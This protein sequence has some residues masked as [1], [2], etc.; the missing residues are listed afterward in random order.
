M[1]RATELTIDVSPLGRARDALATLDG[2]GWT[3]TDELSAVRVSSRPGPLHSLD[4]LA[5]V[6]DAADDVVA[7]SRIAGQSFVLR[8]V[9]G[10]MEVVHVPSLAPREVFEDRDIWPVAERAWSEDVSAVMQ[11][12]LDWVID[13]TLALHRLLAVPAGLEVRVTTSAEALVTMVLGASAWEFDRFLPS[14]AALRLFIALD[15]AGPA[16]R[17]GVLTFAGLEPGIVTVLGAHQRTHPGAAAESADDLP[18]PTL[19]TPCDVRTASGMSW[20]PAFRHIKQVAAYLA[21]SALASSRTVRD[22]SLILTYL[23]FKRL[24]LTLTRD[25]EILPK[26]ADG[27]IVLFL[28]AT[29][30]RSPDKL[31]AIRQVASVY[32]TGAEFLRHPR[33]V[34]DSAEMVYLGLRSD[35]IAEAVRSVRVAETQILE[36]V[37]QTARATQDLLKSVTDRAIA[38][39][40][41]VGGVLIANASK[42][43]PTSTGRGLLLV[44]ATFLAFLGIWSLVVEG[45]LLSLPLRKLLEDFD[46]RPT[47]LSERQRFELR[48]LPTVMA[49][50]SKLRLVQ[51][52]VPLVYVAAAALVVVFGHPDRFV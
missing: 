31:L 52:A 27:W 29:L 17:A 22:D 47:S 16:V 20:E 5:D 43:L 39:L 46:S 11:L 44:L 8:R 36:V 34:H 40:V 35:A 37:R 2:A 23:G 41:A 6:L 45:P 13:A 25:A 7:T 24:T 3:I 49:M 51:F 48:K 19:L 10:Q 33:D 15:A 38:T 4:L 30:E 32:E 18:S 28:W 12:P 1:T 21:L 9:R 26:D 42:V 50:R 14:P